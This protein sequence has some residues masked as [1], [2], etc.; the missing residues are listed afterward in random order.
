MDEVASEQNLFNALYPFQSGN[1]PRTPLGAAFTR[2]VFFMTSCRDEMR[3]NWQCRGPH[4]T[5]QQWLNTFNDWR[6]QAIRAVETMEAKLDKPHRRAKRFIRSGPVGECEQSAEL[7]SPLS[8]Q[9]IEQAIL[10]L[11]N[12]LDSSTP[13]AGSI[14]EPRS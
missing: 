11:E 13:D 1:L 2:S 12:S 7:T 3:L 14:I 6:R 8:E 4:S 9:S 10:D 5:H